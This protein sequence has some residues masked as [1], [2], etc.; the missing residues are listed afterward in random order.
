[1]VRGSVYDTEIATIIINLQMLTQHESMTSFGKM[2]A[3]NLKQNSS[4]IF[5]KSHFGRPGGT[6]E[7]RNSDPAIMLT[8]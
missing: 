2:L 1:M 4:L 8:V 3:P 6:K 5:P 7:Q